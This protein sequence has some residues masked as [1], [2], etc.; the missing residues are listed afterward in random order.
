M[1]PIG[2]VGINLAV[3]DAVAAANILAEPLRRGTVTIDM[4]Q[5]GPAAPRISHS[6]N[7][8]PVDYHA[9]Q[10]DPTGAREQEQTAEGTTVHENYAMAAVAAPSRSSACFRCSPG[11]HS[12]A[13][14]VMSAQGA[15]TIN[16][17][18]SI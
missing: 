10:C 18:L 3:Q 4:L 7:A 12:Y 15:K 16:L 6:R 11:A 2:G 1:S 14:G 8:A 9:E 5:A 13:G 17:K